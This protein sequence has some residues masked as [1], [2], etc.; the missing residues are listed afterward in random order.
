MSRKM[1]E[2]AEPVHR[3]SCVF[4][5]VTHCIPCLYRSLKS[6]NDGIYDLVGLNRIE[7]LQW[8]SEQMSKWKWREAICHLLKTRTTSVTQSESLWWSK[9]NAYVMMLV[10]FF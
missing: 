7:N 4:V 6:N 3:K 1:E 2:M 5:R 10:T 9:G 8:R